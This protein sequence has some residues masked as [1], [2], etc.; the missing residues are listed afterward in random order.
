MSQGSNEVEK[1][2]PVVQAT[3]KVTEVYAFH[4]SGACPVSYDLLRLTCERESECRAAGH[5]A[6]CKLWDD[7]DLGSK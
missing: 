6:E 2:C 4:S 7:Y 1:F 3:V 5:Y